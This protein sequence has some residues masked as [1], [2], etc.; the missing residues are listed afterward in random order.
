MRWLSGVLRLLLHPPHRRHEGMYLG[1]HAPT[2]SCHDNRATAVQPTCH[3]ACTHRHAAQSYR[4]PA[5]TV[6]VRLQVVPPPATAMSVAQGIVK[7]DGVG[8]LYAGV[9]AAILRQATYGTARIGLH[10]AFSDK[11]KAYN[12]GNNIPFWQKF[13]RCAPL[14]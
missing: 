11:L 3:P 6:Q 13:C 9:G 2:Y 8:G 12:G 5:S 14:P 7:A 4:L 10:S 1:F